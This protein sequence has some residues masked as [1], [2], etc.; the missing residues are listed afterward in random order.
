MV[1]TKEM[2][3]A[4]PEKYATIPLEMFK[5]MVS[6]LPSVK[7]QLEIESSVVVTT[8][9]VV[10]NETQYLP[11]TGVEKPPKFKQNVYRPGNGARRKNGSLGRFG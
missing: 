5:E 3:V 1:K 11:E 9:N 7:R 10:R 6:L 2:A 4:R 8:K